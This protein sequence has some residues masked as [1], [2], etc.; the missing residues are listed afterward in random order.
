MP[1]V[2]PVDPALGF[3]VAQHVKSDHKLVKE[4]LFDLIQVISGYLN[5]LTLGA[6]LGKQFQCHGIGK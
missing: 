4:Y 5:A 2:G 6:G 3:F 1:V